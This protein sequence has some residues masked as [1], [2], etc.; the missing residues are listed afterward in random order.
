VGLILRKVLTAFIMPLPLA[1][2]VG[3]TGWVLWVRGKRTKLGRR[4]VAAA[5]VGL[6]LVSIEPVA[7]SLAGAVEG[8]LPPFPGDSVAYVVVLGNGHTSDPDIPATARLHPQALYRVTEGVRIALAQPWSRLVFSGYGGRDP[9]SNAEVNSDLALQL[10]IPGE[11]IIVESRPTS[12][13]HEAELLEP[14]LRGQTF[15]LV[16]SA[17]HMGRSLSLFRARGLNPIP[18]PTGHLARVPQ[19]F[20]LLGLVPRESNLERTRAVWYETL[21]RIWAKLRGDS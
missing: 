3:V 19:G 4:M 15:A 6:A 7:R 11:R 17:S 20:D 14:I 9:R 21:G 1:L 2:I 10:G 5:F 12:T 18:A 13:A 8:D 16:T